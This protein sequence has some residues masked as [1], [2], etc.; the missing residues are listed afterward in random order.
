MPR[1]YVPNL[2]A[3]RLM[4]RPAQ[5]ADARPVPPALTL[6]VGLGHCCGLSFQSP[7]MHGS[8]TWSNQNSTFNSQPSQLLYLCKTQ[9]RTNF[10]G[11]TLPHSGL[12]KCA[13]H[14]T[15]STF[16]GS[17]KRRHREGWRGCWSLHSRDTSPEGSQDPWGQHFPRLRIPV[18]HSMGLQGQRGRDRQ[19]GYRG[20]TGA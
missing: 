18:Q 2:E 5:E 20:L 19:H 12:G 4:P 16:L 13:E 1:I 10:S 9:F 7:N 8:G 14:P 11:R 15:Y 17:L 6:H 3:G